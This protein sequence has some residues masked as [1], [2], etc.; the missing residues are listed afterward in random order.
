MLT[1]SL[2]QATS[3][4]IAGHLT[5]FL[6]IELSA[7]AQ[8][9]FVC[10]LRTLRT[11]LTHKLRK[12]LYHTVK[13]LGVSQWTPGSRLAKVFEALSGIVILDWGEP[14]SLSADFAVRVIT[15]I[16]YPSR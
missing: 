12:C 8:K 5:R 9:C 13:S 6:L 16:G 1:N 2:R 14:A 11:S 7:S 3:N 10:V 4:D 15:R